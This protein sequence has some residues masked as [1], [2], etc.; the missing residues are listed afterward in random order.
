MCPE[1]GVANPIKV[2]ACLVHLPKVHALRLDFFPTINERLLNLVEVLQQSIPRLLSRLIW[3][4][5]KSEGNNTLAITTR[6]IEFCSQSNVSIGGAGIFP[7]HLL[8][9]VDILPT[10]ADPYV[11]TAHFPECCGTS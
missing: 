9:G 6:Q 8:V 2:E 10:I 11:S 7:C 4:S 1:D 5:S 3:R